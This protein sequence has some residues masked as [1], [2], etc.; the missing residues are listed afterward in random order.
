[1]GEARRRAAADPTFGKPKRGLIISA[2]VEITGDSVLI[3]SGSP[4]L[5][6]LRA[7]L[8]YWDKLAWPTNNS[9]FIGGGPDIEFLEQAKVL[10]RPTYRFAGSG[11]AA[12]IRAQAETLL[13]LDTREPGVWALSQ[14]ENSILVR[15]GILSQA[16]GV[17]L[18]LYDA[19]PVP[20]KGV[21]LN[22]VLEFRLK[23]YDELQGLRLEIDG[24]VEKISASKDP[25]TELE[26]CRRHI[27]EKCKAAIRVASEWQFPV[28]LSNL[29]ASF[30]LKPLSMLRDG[31]VAYAGAVAL[32]ATS[33]LAAA[34]TGATA[35]SSLKIT[36]D[37]G[38]Q[39]LKARTNPYRYV[40]Q[41]HRELF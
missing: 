7:S 5:Q 29:K 18:E 28:R 22:E 1:M 10:I 37:L 34:L 19:I 36:G 41:F 21:P 24:L 31:L 20:D 2:P 3:N 14:G 40:S 25:P 15:D 6:E 16:N 11:A 27:D 9:I 23:R 17:A 8:L 39:G 35:L 32:G 33:A 13:N 30:D 26:N 12:L 4:D 38:W